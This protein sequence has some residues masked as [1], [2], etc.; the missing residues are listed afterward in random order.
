MRFGKNR[1]YAEAALKVRQIG[2]YCIRKRLAALENK[3]EVPNDILTLILQTVRE[4]HL[5]ILFYLLCTSILS[6]NITF[7]CLYTQYGNLKSN[8]PIPKINNYC[9]RE[10]FSSF[11]YPYVICYYD[12]ETEN[13]IDMDELVDDFVSFYVAGT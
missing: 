2:E 10:I 5:Q 11:N 3:Q 9:S 8:K 6:E 1:S 12:L 4:L 13:K 7:T